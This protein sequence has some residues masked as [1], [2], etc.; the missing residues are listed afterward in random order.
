VGLR[1]VPPTGGFGTTLV[2]SL[3]RQLHADVA[4]EQRV[5]GGGTRARLTLP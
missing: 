1:S 2:R 3:A 4:W 5:P